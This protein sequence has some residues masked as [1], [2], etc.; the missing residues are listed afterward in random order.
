MRYIDSG[1]RSAEHAVA[2]WLDAELNEHAA[3]LRIQSGFFSRDALRPFLARFE[4][5]VAADGIV[6]VVVGSN[7]GQTLADH[8]MELAQALGLPRAKSQLGVVYLSGAYFHPKTIH[9]RRTDGSQTAYVGSANFTL[10]G[11]AA[12]PDDAISTGVCLDRH[13][14]AM[15][16]PTPATLIL[17]FGVSRDYVFLSPAPIMHYA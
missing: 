2:T 9:I 10:P 17:G 6:N 8:V 5:L 11:I 1:T 13:F 16:A 4:A 12:K 7:E 3:E 14:I 15:I